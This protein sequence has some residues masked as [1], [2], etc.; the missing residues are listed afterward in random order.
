MAALS[1]FATR[2][3]GILVQVRFEESDLVTPFGE[4]YRRSRVRVGMLLPF[5]RIPSVSVTAD[6][7]APAQ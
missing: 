4:R 5:K 1:R 7:R 2:D 3:A 6:L